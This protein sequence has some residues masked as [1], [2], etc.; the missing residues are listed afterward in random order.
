MS[1][2]WICMSCRTS[3]SDMVVKKRGRMDEFHNASE[4]VLGT[5]V[6]VSAEPR[7]QEVQEGTET[8][9]SRSQD[10][11]SD[12]LDERHVGAQA[13]MDAALH[14]LHVGFVLVQDILECGDHF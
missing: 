1:M 14:A 3:P 7:R 5:M 6:P 10:V 13:L 4:G 9:A 12:L 2:F 11:F 8:F